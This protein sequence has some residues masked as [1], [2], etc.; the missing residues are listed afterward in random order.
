MSSSWLHPKLA[1]T[2]AQW[3]ASCRTCFRLY[4]SSSSSNHLQSDKR[5]REIY[6]KKSWSRLKVHNRFSIQLYF[7]TLEPQLRASPIASLKPILERKHPK[8]PLQQLLHLL[9]LFILELL[10]CFSTSREHC[11]VSCLYFKCF[12]LL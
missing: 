9:Y 3:L 11:S 7:K 2:S 8:N 1:N 12:Q 5:E 6:Q 4:Y 10:Q